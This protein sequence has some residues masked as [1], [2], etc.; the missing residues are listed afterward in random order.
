MGKKIKIS[1]AIEDRLLEIYRT[2]H[3]TESFLTFF[4]GVYALLKVLNE[5]KAK[6]RKPREAANK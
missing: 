3:G 1:E 2:S 6:K 5:D 4:E